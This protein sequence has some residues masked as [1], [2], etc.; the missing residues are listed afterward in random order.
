M[1]VGKGKFWFSVRNLPR[2]NTCFSCQVREGMS[3]KTPLLDALPDRIASCF[4]ARAL[5][6]FFLLKKWRDRDELPYL[7]GVFQAGAFFKIP[8][9]KSS[10]AQVRSA[11]L[12]HHISE[13]LMIFANWISRCGF[14][15]AVWGKQM[16]Q[17]FILWFPGGRGDLN[18]QWARAPGNEPYW[19][20][21]TPSA[22][23]QIVYHEA[24][25]SCI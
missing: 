21:S 15:C 25:F 9:G 17:A 7:K 1:Y 12:W 11:W 6:P 2:T 3:S 14:I 20:W 5:N 22:F 23:L 19:P 8:C 16:N 13:S 24:T 4:S 10:V 18:T